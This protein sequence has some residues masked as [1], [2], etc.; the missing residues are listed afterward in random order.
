VERA[1]KDG[2]HQFERRPVEVVTA[3]DDR[4]MIHSNLK[5]GDRL[6]TK[7]AAILFSRDFFKTPV[8]EDD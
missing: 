2:K 5:D 7:G 3:V 8:A 1:E 4:L 6:V